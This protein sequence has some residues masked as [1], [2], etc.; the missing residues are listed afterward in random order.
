MVSALYTVSHAAKRT[1][2]VAGY[3]SRSSVKYLPLLRV[4][5]DESTIVETTK[6][7]H[8][9]EFTSNPRKIVPEIDFFYAPTNDCLLLIRL[10]RANGC[11]SDP[12]YVVVAVS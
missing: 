3:N 6:Y 7:C 10:A 8:R 11:P 2:A 1:V 5:D 4:T 9:T 12:H